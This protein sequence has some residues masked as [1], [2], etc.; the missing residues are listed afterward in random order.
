MAL[1]VSEWLK[2]A[3]IDG[4]KRGTIPREM[5]IIKTVDYN[6]KGILSDDQLSEIAAEIEAFDASIAEGATS[7]LDEEV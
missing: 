1:N 5:A 4:V 6:A 3:L 7:I 2:K